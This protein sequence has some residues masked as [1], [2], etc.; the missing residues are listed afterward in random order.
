MKKL[1]SLLMLMAINPVFAMKLL[2]KNTQLL[3]Y[4]QYTVER[5]Y[6]HS[7]QGNQATYRRTINGKP[8][9]P[10]TITTH[11]TI[12]QL[13]KHSP[14]IKVTKNRHSS[15]NR[16]QRIFLSPNYGGVSE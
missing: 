3:D 2:P 8:A 4:S 10:V 13:K 9:N 14:I 12:Q 6:L 7:K 5:L 1:L 16:T 15:R 11:L